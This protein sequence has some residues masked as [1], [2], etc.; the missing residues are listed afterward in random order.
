[1]RL[2]TLQRRVCF[3]I[4]INLFILILVFGTNVYT[5]PTISLETDTKKITQLSFRPSLN[6]PKLKVPSPEGG[7]YI[8][9]DAVNIFGR[10]E[11]SNYGF[12]QRRVEIYVNDIYITAVYSNGSNDIGNGF[13]S[14]YDIAGYYSASFNLSA[15]ETHAGPNNNI[16]EYC[17]GNGESLQPFIVHQEMVTVYQHA[18]LN[19]TGSKTITSNLVQIQFQT[20]FGSG[21]G[22]P[23]IP[24]TASLSSTPPEISL[25]SP[26]TPLGNGY[27]LSNAS[28]YIDFYLYSSN[29]NFNQN[30]TL[31]ALAN[32][33]GTSS[34]GVG[35][36]YDGI[37]ESTNTADAQ[38]ELDFLA[39][40]DTTPPSVSILSPQDGSFVLGTVTIEVRATDAR[41]GI[42]ECWLT[43]GVG[44]SIPST[45]LDPISQSG[46]IYTF[47]VDARTALAETVTIYAHA[48]D[49]NNLE[50]QASITVTT[51]I[52]TPSVTI[53][54]PTP[55]LTVGTV[56]G[57]TQLSIN[58][59]VDDS[60]STGSSITSGIALVE[61]QIG[62]GAY[63]PATEVTANTRYTYLWDTIT[64]AQE[65]Y[66]T[67][68]VRVTDNAGNQGSDSV[69]VT[70]DNVPEPD[71]DGDGLSDADEQNYSTDPNDSD[72]DDDGLEDGEE[73]HA[74]GTDPLDAD[75]DD[76]GLEDGEEVNTYGTDP[77]DSDTDD[78][79]LEDDWEVAYGLNPT[80]D[81]AS[82]DADGDGLTNTE[83]YQA[84]SNPN[85]A[86]TD[87]DGLDD[88]EEVNTHNTDPASADTDGDGLD[89]AE[90]INIHGTDPNNSDTDADGISDGEEVNSHNTDPQ[91]G[92]TDSDG[93]PDGWEILYGLN[94][95]LYDS[96]ADLDGD[97]LSNG[98]EYT[99]GSNPTLGDSDGDSIPDGEEVNLGT[100][101]SNPDSDG[102]G[103]PDDWEVNNGL[104]PTAND[105]GGDADNDGLSNG[106]EYIQNTD[107]SNP[108]SDGDGVSDGNEGSLG[109]DP[110][111]SD[112][113]DDGLND[114]EE[115]NI[116]TDPTS[117]DSDND[118]MD[119]YWEYQNQL[120]PTQNDANND[121]D[122]DGIVNLQ[123]YQQ[124]TNP[125]IAESL[126]PELAPFVITPI[127][128]VISSIISFVAG[129]I[130]ADYV[131]KQK[132]RKRRR[133]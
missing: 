75:S 79:G 115:Q 93:M 106:S 90:E 35:E 118:G 114:G 2:F 22:V 57:T 26:N 24:I 8:T 109:S 12:A 122:G 29:S 99:Y 33:T 113:D 10:V 40:L 105:A 101:P 13:G 14:D 98:D 107:P 6:S 82:N 47:E 34:Y 95:N 36:N 56:P 18:F 130:T 100:D 121:P 15:S 31:N 41:S 108:D 119:D 88:A 128:I 72:S 65:G 74:Y 81:D 112:S 117:G 102:D 133:R 132:K 61:V 86:D 17:L 91:S 39:L 78:D 9:G 126:I 64:A 46:N 120:N 73:V 16:T 68:R 60:G 124:M 44:S 110:N 123:E 125:Q 21:T 66:T 55:D 104:N 3:V 19:Y 50:T 85:L 1:M 83:E 67:I 62:A 23:N 111:D 28:G 38:V 45:R 63:L 20:H 103:M 27:Y 76:D 4:C 80:V 53:T 59:D 25:T 54:N 49:R 70:V 116:G 87:G 131:K 69:G 11:V 84:G 129:V 58:I 37:D 96:A 97:G 32:Y 94:P 92:D 30:L 127:L 51:D 77:L 43:F 42:D 7:F 48:K 52:T 89:D 5:A 71:A